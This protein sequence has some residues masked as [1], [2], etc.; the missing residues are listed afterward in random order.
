MGSG[1]LPARFVRANAPAAA[2]AAID[3]TY[4]ARFTMGND[5]LEQEIL[6]LFA[7][8]APHYLHRLRM[9]ATDADWKEAAH[10][11]KGSAA[12]VG[13]RHLQRCAELA[14]RV[15]MRFA[16]ADREAQRDWALR[17]IAE[18]TA[19][20]CRQIGQMFGH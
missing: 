4:L 5:A 3:R 1:G 20:A 10:T 13:A 7:A 6:E 9:A 2:G 11:I 17:S 16:S 19:A 8:Q 12:A 14:E 18:A 15:D